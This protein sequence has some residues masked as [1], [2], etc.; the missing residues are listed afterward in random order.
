MIESINTK[1]ENIFSVIETTGRIFH[2]CLIIVTV[3]ALMLSSSSA[4]GE[5]TTTTIITKQSDSS[6]NGTSGVII[7]KN[8]DSAQDG[9]SG[10][11]G[12]IE[13]RIEDLIS[14]AANITS[15]IDMQ[16]SGK[17]ASSVMNID[18]GNIERSFFG[19][20]SADVRSINNASF[21]AEFDVMNNSSVEGHYRIDN[22]TLSSLQ[23][24]NE[25][26]V[27]GGTVDVTEEREEQSW[28][29]SP[30]T[31]LVLDN[32]VL[33]ISFKASELDE[34]FSGQPVIGI[35]ANATGL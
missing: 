20:W 4:V 34:V 2:W 8:Q 32:K 14:S 23:R 33:V 22:L 9:I 28:E 17:I 19:D 24:V 1:I 31:I 12:D 6:Q 7:D 26:V 30:V 15:D 27:L 13:A 35:V 5:Q 18:D 10:T 11:A 21:V 3:I 25:N 29:Q 16:L